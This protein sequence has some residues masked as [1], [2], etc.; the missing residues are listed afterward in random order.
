MPRAKACC[1]YSCP[2]RVLKL[3]NHQIAWPLAE[4]MNISI[5]KGVFASKLK[6]AKIEF[7]CCVMYSGVEYVVCCYSDSVLLRV[8]LLN[9]Y[10]IRNI[11]ISKEL[12]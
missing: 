7:Y 6:H 9:S 11:L 1:L 8:L 4:I 3:I 5:E 10:H 12:D 2:I